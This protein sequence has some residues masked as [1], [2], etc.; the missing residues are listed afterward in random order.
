MTASDML[1]K[2]QRNLDKRENI[3]KPS[4][5]GEPIEIKKQE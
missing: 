3:K 5:N 1:R 4:T 2:Q